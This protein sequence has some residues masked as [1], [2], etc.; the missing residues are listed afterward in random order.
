MSYLPKIRI[1]VL[2]ILVGV[3]STSAWFLSDEA[4]DAVMTPTI[5]TKPVSREM[6]GAVS[7]AT[8]K[9]GNTVR[10]DAVTVSPPGVWVAVHEIMEEGLGNVLGAARVHGPNIEVLVPLLR[11]T[12]AGQTYAI[13]LYRDDGNGEFNLDKDSVYVDFD[14]GT[15]VTAYFTTT[16]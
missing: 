8:Q 11:G 16:Q 4:P 12:E 3:A 7:V 13:V 10:V 1:F 2:G 6:S 9:A 14:T 15:R 5:S